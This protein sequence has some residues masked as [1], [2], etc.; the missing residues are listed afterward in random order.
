MGGCKTNE[1]KAEHRGKEG[2]NWLFLL[3]PDACLHLEIWK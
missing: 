2:K 3:R 1:F